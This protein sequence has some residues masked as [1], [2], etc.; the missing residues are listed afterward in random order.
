MAQ[1]PIQ[2][3]VG[4]RDETRSD[5]TV[6]VQPLVDHRHHPLD[7]EVAGEESPDFFG[8]LTGVRDHAAELKV[9]DES[10]RSALHQFFHGY[11]VV[12][13]HPFHSV[14]GNVVMFAAAQHHL[15]L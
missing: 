6:P 2:A 13:E 14:I 5:A 8:H 1:D 10:V 3:R 4:S 9:I 11:Q 7:V 15:L 12:L